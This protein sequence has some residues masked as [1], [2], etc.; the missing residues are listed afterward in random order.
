MPPACARADTASVRILIESGIMSWRYGFYAMMHRAGPSLTGRPDNLIHGQ[1]SVNTGWPLP[2]INR[3]N[4]KQK[5]PSK[6]HS[7]VFQK[8]T[9]FSPCFVRTGWI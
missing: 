3:K 6:V 1:E 4:K 9:D 2:H 7:K 8:K 5:I